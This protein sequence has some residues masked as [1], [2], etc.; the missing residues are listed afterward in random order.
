MELMGSYN[1]LN[2]EDLLSHG[3]FRGMLED[4]K[5][6]HSVQHVLI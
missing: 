2:E 4:R 5:F 1:S 6:M 3:E